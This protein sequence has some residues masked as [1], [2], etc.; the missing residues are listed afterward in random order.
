MYEEFIQNITNQL[1]IHWYAILISL[2]IG[3]ILFYPL[4]KGDGG[5]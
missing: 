3:D 4:G 5:E 1:S 2:A